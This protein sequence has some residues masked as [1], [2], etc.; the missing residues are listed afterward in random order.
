MINKKIVIDKMS[1][2]YT[3]QWCSKSFMLDIQGTLNASSIYDPVYSAAG[4]KYIKYTELSVMLEI[5][6]KN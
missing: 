4:A 6:I 2:S 3:F 1:S 5:Y